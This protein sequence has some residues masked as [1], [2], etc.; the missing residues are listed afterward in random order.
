[1]VFLIISSLYG[2]FELLPLYVADNSYR[3]TRVGSAIFLFG[4]DSVI[5]IQFLLR[6]PYKSCPFCEGSVLLKKIILY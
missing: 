5:G 1:M 3:S 6:R 4:G 2:D